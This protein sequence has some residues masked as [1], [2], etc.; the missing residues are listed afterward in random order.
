[1]QIPNVRV[2]ANNK[3]FNDDLVAL[4]YPAVYLPNVYQKKVTSDP[5]P[6]KIGS[7]CS[8]LPNIYPKKATSQNATA[9]LF[10]IHI[11]I[12]CFGAIRLLK[13]H[14]GQAVAAMRFANQIGRE[15]HFHINN[16]CA[17]PVDNVLKNLRA[18][19]AGTEHVLVEHSWLP[20]D[21]FC[22][23]VAMMDLGLQVS[24][25][26]SFNI[27]TA[28]F[29]HAGVPVVASK[30]VKHVH[31]LFKCHNVTDDIVRGLHLAWLFGGIGLNRRLLAKSNTAAIK[32]WSEFLK[33]VES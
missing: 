9:R 22:E 13:N 21:K 30:E 26:E 33:G 11:N 18:L 10:P 19:F 31:W 4:G 14:V 7:D 28:D 1:V 27:V 29:V 8:Y 6:H 23:L 32:V 20:H 3:E 12:G 25:S 2:S 16:D 5:T 15:L 24:L 17:G